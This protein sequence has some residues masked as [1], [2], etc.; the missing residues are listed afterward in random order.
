MIMKSQSN[1]PGFTLVELLAVIAIIGV[2]AAII[3]PVVFSLRASANASRCMGNLRQMAIGAQ[4]YGNDN[5]GIILPWRPPVGKAYWM[6]SLVPYVGV[7]R[8]PSPAVLEDSVFMC[9][10]E[11]PNTKDEPYYTEDRIRTRYSLNLH[12]TW[13][14]DP[15]V[16][17]QRRTVRYNEL[18]YP[19]RTFLF[20]DLFGAGGGGWGMGASLVYPHKKKVNVAFA[21]GHVDALGK[22]RMDYLCATT[23]HVFWRGYNW[24]GSSTFKTD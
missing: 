16:A 2:L 13:D 18:E 5:K 19:G 3:I 22:E 12:I 15:A 17:W 23:N 6:T 21:D 10:D 24:S 1:S 7:T 20:V 9:P 11:T 8:P 14:G 4:A